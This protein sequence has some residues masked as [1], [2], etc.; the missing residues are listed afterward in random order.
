MGAV[1]AITRLYTGKIRALSEMTLRSPVE[2]AANLR[3]FFTQTLFSQPTWKIAPMPPQDQILFE[4]YENRKIVELRL[5]Q[6]SWL[7]ESDTENGQFQI[8]FKCLKAN[9]AWLIYE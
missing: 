1:E 3:S 8:P 7:F 2:L 9:G 6:T 4:V 5:S